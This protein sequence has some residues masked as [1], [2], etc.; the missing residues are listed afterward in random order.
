MKCFQ[1][2]VQEVKRRL[3]TLKADMIQL[4]ASA[5]RYTVRIQFAGDQGWMNGGTFVMRSH[6]EDKVLFTGPFANEIIV[7][8]SSTMRRDD[9]YDIL[10]FMLFTLDTGQ[11]CQWVGDI[12]YPFW[13]KS[14]EFNVR[15]LSE[16]RF[17]KD[18]IVQTYE[19]DFN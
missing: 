8:A 15:L 10:S 13:G 18:G 6:S 9:G 7:S 16:R 2:G 3:E 12:G 11:M 1:L 19:V 14:K 5:M 17:N 4:P